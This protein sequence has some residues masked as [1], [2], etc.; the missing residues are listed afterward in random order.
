M[1]AAM[2]RA[3]GV[4]PVSLTIA[5]ALVAALAACTDQSESQ[6]SS[7]LTSPRSS[8][9]ITTT[10]TSPAKT[11]SSTLPPPPRG[12]A[13]KAV[14][15]DEFRGS[16]LDT[17]H[18]A[19]CYYWSST[20]C[21]NAST[22]ELE[23]YTPKNVSVAA[24]ELR[25][26]ARREAASS[27]GRRFAFTSG[28]VSGA[29][30]DR[31]MFTF[32]YGYVEARARIPAGA[33]FWSAFWL[34]PSSR[35]ALP[36]VDVFEIVGYAPDVVLEFTHW[37]GTNG[38][39]QFGNASALRASGGGW[40]VYGL[41]WEPSSLTWYVDGRKVWTMDHRPAVPQQDMMLVADLAVGGP[42]ATAPS[43]VTPFPSTM[44]IDYVKVWQH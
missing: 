5:V 20:T 25:L 18:W 26:T 4:G 10:S 22:H 16:A 32:R 41:D 13:W 27:E 33:G 28:M 29:T 44:R 21:T 19:T 8:T 43:A 9:T 36:E 3:P 42:Y 40:H 39:Q 30:P 15:D 11:V 35:S 31:T 37:L 34:L 7:G 17:S 23:L 6:S 1:V 24:G 14:F 2:S 12:S 38:E